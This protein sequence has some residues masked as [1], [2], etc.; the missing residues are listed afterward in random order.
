M[1]C[2]NCGQ[3]AGDYTRICP[4]CGEL[5][6]KGSASAGQTQSSN[7]NYMNYNV[8][9]APVIPQIPDYKVQSV[10]LIVFSCVLC[11]VSCFSILALPFAIVALVNSN[12]ISTHLAAGNF[13]LAQETSRKAKMWC[14]VSFGILLGAVI[15]SIISFIMLVSSGTWQQL[16]EQYMDLYEFDYQW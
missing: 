12:K 16:F 5:L 6:D 15:I 8:S 7:S 9:P 4:A 3:E 14:W 1:Y 13:D 10:L 2:P 11:C